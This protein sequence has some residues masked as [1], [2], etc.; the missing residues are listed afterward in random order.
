MPRRI[1]TYG[2]GGMWEAYNLASTIGAGI[3]AVGV[4][5][6][7]VNVFRTTRHGKRAGND[8]W[9]GD[10]L[11]WLTSSPPPPENFTQPV[12]YVGTARPLRD[13]RMKLKERDAL[14]SA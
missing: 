8:P 2:N 3:M 7:F 9:M 5:L 10:T 14:G 12:P 1:Y 13:L 4:L 6:F 11:E